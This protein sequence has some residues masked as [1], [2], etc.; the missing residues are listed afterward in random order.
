[1]GDQRPKIEQRIWQQVLRALLLLGITLF[2]IALAPTFWRFRVDWVLIAVVSWTLL[3]GLQPGL[4]W[5][6][7]GGIAL[8]L[9]GVQPVGSHLLALI[10][11][12]FAVVIVTEPLDRD[13]P[14][15]VMASVLGASVIY[16]VVLAAILFFVGVRLPWHLL[17]FVDIVPTAIINTIAA[18]PTYLLFRRL[19]RRGQPI[20]G[21]ELGA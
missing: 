8:D 9:L 5:A 14:L 3:R 7:Y 6:F 19:H 21:A 18:I 11:C 2:Q 17:P 10:L 12:V 20:V 4:R 16:G 1:M 13:Q 15:L